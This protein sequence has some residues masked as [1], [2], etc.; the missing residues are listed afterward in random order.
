MNTLI[1]SLEQS[2]IKES[3]NNE[4]HKDI[5]IYDTFTKVPNLLIN[6]TGFQLIVI[7]KHT[8]C[9]ENTNIRFCRTFLYTRYVWFAINIQLIVKIVFQICFY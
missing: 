2:V 6:F 4:N 8:N 1:T 5:N 9:Y 7:Y 3:R